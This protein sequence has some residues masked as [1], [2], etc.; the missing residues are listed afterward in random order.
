MPD[1][2]DIPWRPF[3]GAK[4][5]PE[6]HKELKLEGLK[7]KRYNLISKKTKQLMANRSRGGRYCRQL[8]PFKK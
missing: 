3:L 4:K 8:S 7:M 1:P 5:L 2:T 6:R